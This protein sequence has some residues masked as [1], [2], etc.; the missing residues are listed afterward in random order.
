M[1]FPKDL[2]SAGLVN[3]TVGSK[4]RF[5]PQVEGEATIAVDL[6]A[7]K[8]EYNAGESNVNKRQEK[9]TEEH[10]LST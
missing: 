4:L 10:E 7:A 9:F 3:I 8:I 6:K 1:F 2:V 5:R